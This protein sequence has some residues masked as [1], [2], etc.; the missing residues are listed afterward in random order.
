MPTSWKHSLV[1]PILKN[2]KPASEPNSYRPV[3]LISCVSKLMEKM[4]AGRLYWQLE[5]QGKLKN[6][7]SGFRKGRSTEDLI[8]KMEHTVR[9]SLVNRKVNMTIFF[10]L[11]QAFDNVNHNLLLYKVA[12]AGIN[13]RMIGWLEQFLY[14]RT[15]QYIIDN[16][17]SEARPVKRG[18]PQGSALSPLIFNIMMMDLPFVENAGL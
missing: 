16:D 7:Q 6:L 14:N 17:R 5:N 18:L 10:D 13:G 11:K 12:K 1:I 3:S 2:G 9:A 8:L 4:V 15:F